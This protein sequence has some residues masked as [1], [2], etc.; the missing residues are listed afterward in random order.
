MARISLEPSLAG[1]NNERIQGTLIQDGIKWSFNTPAASHQGGIWERLIG[2][3]KGILSSVVGQ[4]VLDDEGLQTLFCEVETI[5]NDRPITKV[6][7]DP[8]DLEALTPNHILLLK[9]KP[10]FPP[11]LFEQSDLY[12]RRRWKQVQ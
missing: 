6:S 3:V 2:S 12:T 11:G 1:L 7:D 4:Q 5:L 9:G 10:I 8:N